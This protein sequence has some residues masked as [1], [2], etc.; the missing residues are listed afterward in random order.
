MLSLKSDEARAV[1]LVTAIQGGDTESLQRLLRDDPNLAAARVVDRGGVSRTLLH[2]AADW[3][4]HFRNGAQTV[5]DPGRRW[6]GRRRARR[7]SRSPRGA[8]NRAALGREQR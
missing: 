7:S 6:S 5:V 1:A 2:V 4:G 8:G 3:P